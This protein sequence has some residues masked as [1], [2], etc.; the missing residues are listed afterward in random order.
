MKLTPRSVSAFHPPFAHARPP[1]PLGW[2]ARLLR[3]A[4]PGRGRE[5]VEALLA[6]REPGDVT[7]TD[8]SAALAAYNL[9]GRRAR[10]VLRE[11]WRQALLH[12]LAD[13]AL[14]DREAD[15]LEAL[16]TTLGLSGRE[17]EEIERAVVHP[18]YRKALADVLA[19]GEIS[20]Y[21][22][23]GLATLRDRLRIP[24]DIE[25][26]LYTREAE[27]ALRRTAEMATADERLSPDEHRQLEWLASHLGIPFAL[28]DAT[29]ERLDR[30][31]L[32]WR[33]ENE[34]PPALNVSVVLEPG[35]QCYFTGRASW[36]E[37]W[38]RRGG[39]RPSAPPVQLTRGVRY[40]VGSAPLPAV[41]RAPLT[42]IDEG[43]LY[44]TNRRIRLDGAKQTRSL[45]YKFVTGLQVY[46]D[47]VV[48]ERVTGKHPYL[49]LDG[50]VELAAAVVS[51]MMAGG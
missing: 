40:R 36:Y 13:D 26:T 49:I 28:D 25:R 48:V 4:N 3:L 19:D 7:A 34:D 16:R 5:A 20:Q 32:L 2:L 31:A 1:A 42:L 37:N 14:S 8:V 22:R 15:Y 29:R 17:A 30:Y 51:G 47:A 24:L 43:T 33:I 27:Q 11:V 38:A 21:E 23:E 46:A 35:E 10:G 45:R 6:G 12:L 9:H 44:V 18:R 39:T 50:D 41:D